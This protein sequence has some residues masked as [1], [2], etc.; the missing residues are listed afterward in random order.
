[1]AKTQFELRTVGVRTTE[2][3]LTEGQQS[4]AAL[5]ADSLATVIGGPGSGKT[6]AIKAMFLR[7]AQA[8]GAG[9][10]PSSVLILA[11]SR[12]A[13]TRLRDELAIDF[14]G[15]TE[16][17]LAR[18]V[19]SFAFALLRESALREGSKL[20]E[21][22]SGAEQDRI[23]A[24]IIEEMRDGAFGDLSWPKHV[25]KTVRQLNG[26]RAELRD[27]L[28]VCLEH[29]R[30]PAR[31]AALG[32][33]F[34]KPEW[35]AAAVLYQRYL[36]VLGT[37]ENAHRYDPS[38][39][40]VEATKYLS[41]LDQEG[42]A[43]SPVPALQ[44]IKL[45][46]V[47]DAHE[48]TPSAQA[49]LLALVG[50]SR[51]LVVFADPDSTTL[52]FRAADPH[53]FGNLVDRVAAIQARAAQRVVLT[54]PAG[55]RNPDISHALG[56]ITPKI[57]V[58]SESKQRLAA[59][60]RL[61]LGKFESSQETSPAGFEAHGFETGIQ[62][63][64]W[65][66]RR[67]RELHLNHGVAW[68]DMAVVARSGEQL[69]LLSLALASE[70]VPVRVLGAQSPLRDEFGSRHLLELAQ[71]LY[72][73]QEITLELALR[74]LQSP[75]CG[76]D[77]LA[78]RRFKRQLR[79]A[80]F[81]SGQAEEKS[82]N[83][84]IVDAFSS[85]GSMVTYD[86]PE[87]IQ[88]EEFLKVF[89][90]AKDLI[91]SNRHTVEDLLWHLWSN[92]DASDRWFAASR[93]T[94]ELALQAN[95]NLDA[96]VALFGAANR[97]VE[98]TPNA[99]GAEFIERSL[100]QGVPEDSLSLNAR[101]RNRVE[102]VTPSG[103]I[104]RRYR[105]VALP[106]LQEGTWPNLKP[107][108]SLLLAMSL[109]SYLLNPSVA[110]KSEANQTETLPYTVNPEIEDERRMLH[111]AIGAATEKVLISAIE[112]EE[113][114]L[115]QFMNLLFEEVETLNYQRPQFTLRGMAGE[116]RKQLADPDLHDGKEAIAM[117]LLELH[118]HKVPGAHPSQWL[119]LRNPSTAEPLVDLTDPAHMVQ[120][121]PSQLE[122]FL[123]CPLHWFIESH[124]GNENEFQ[125]RVGTLIH[126]ALEKATKAGS[127]SAT[128]ASMWQTIESKW[129]R[130]DFES[131]WLEQA[132]KR[133]AARML[134]K[135][136]Q[137]L[138]NVQFED[139]FVVQTEASF[140]IEY[141]GVRLRGT[142]DRVEIFPDGRVRIADLKTSRKKLSGPQVAKHPQ[143]GLYQ[144]AAQNHGFD[145]EPGFPETP[146]FD[147]A[148][149]IDVGD[150]SA[151][152]KP[153]GT[154]QG[155]LDE[156]IDDETGETLRQFIDASIESARLGMAMPEL[157]L[158]A[159]IGTHCYDKY[160]FGSC[161]IHLAK[162]VSYG[163]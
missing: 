57:P 68:Q 91:S 114:Q 22:I 94:G 125:A 61:A 45:V 145:D 150:D 58:I 33:Q 95:R 65:L 102:L 63:A 59:G 117:A 41:K 25:D 84:L 96:V 100:A 34:N 18:T 38:M 86:A 75:L 42:G 9:F 148:L 6:T 87:S 5:G 110:V 139:G 52:G 112:N 17:P 109:A 60:K 85:R 3:T 82:S 116:L 50:K 39:L 126:E 13:A 118:S 157:N 93:G 47:D 137:Y 142:A 4:A 130:L 26:F 128:E 140:D 158:A 62:E 162:A 119:G 154:P 56:L 16:G 35:R 76:L 124:G 64:S 1:M 89:F 155:K 43:S 74:L 19:S 31:L 106:G 14:Q 40:I 160:S 101:A 159:K 129:H 88:V 108:S 78:L 79:R 163:A 53:L 83:D 44:R 113:S 48:L 51:G 156:V 90:D 29:D 67:L 10:D 151:K 23:L 104:G 20:P 66:A 32:E 115:S 28:M 37:A 7:Q 141:N 24:T 77:N 122:K 132:E 72:S 70:S 136:V 54:P 98:R 135:I 8:V 2:L 152:F 133:R 55:L 111:K 123:D 147:G 69:E 153:E 21:L 134:N 149:I 46:V 11:A 99:N 138:S 127:D 120:V 105:V 143:L 161:R 144:I 36:E 15:A 12:D 97:F 71:I 73:G 30:P 146:E 92:S 27:L 81:E 107:R 103:L 131:E 121:S 49:F 80:V